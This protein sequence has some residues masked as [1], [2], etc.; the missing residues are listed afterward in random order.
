MGRQYPTGFQVIHYEK[1]IIN[2]A[3]A[4]AVA[5]GYFLVPDYILVDPDYI[6][7]DP[8]YILVPDY[9]LVPGYILAPP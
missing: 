5:P 3:V 1:I 9:F 7:V 6:L 4:L 8:G 2:T